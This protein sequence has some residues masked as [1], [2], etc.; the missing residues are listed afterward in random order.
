MR[1]RL[2]LVVAALLLAATALPAQAASSSQPSSI[3]VPASWFGATPPL[4]PGQIELAVTSSLPSTVTGESA[5]IEVR[6]LKAGDPLTV[7]R[8]GTDVTGALGPVRDGV[9]GGVVRD[10]RV[11]TNTLTATSGA[12]RAALEV[13][14]HRITG[15]VISGP[16]QTPFVCETVANGMGKPLDADCSAPTQV[17]WYARSVSTRF[18]KLADP[19]APYPPD[20][21][22]TTTADGKTVPFVVRVESSVIN[23]S[24]TRVAVLD[25][26]HSRPPGAAYTPS[27]A[28]NRKLIYSFGESC[29]TGH[30][31][32]V[33]SAEN[34]L[35]EVAPS[36]NPYDNAFAPFLDLG[37]EL[38]KG[39]MTAHSTLTILGVECN[40]VVSAETLM[41][42]KE[43][44]IKDYGPLVHTLGAGA[45]GGA[46][47][48]YTAANNYP[49]IIDGGNAI[50][51]FPDMETTFVT[52][53]DCLLLERAFRADPL[54]WTEPKQEAVTGFRTGQICSDWTSQYA[55]LVDPKH[56]DPSVPAA[57][58]YDPR[59]NPGGVRCA[60]QDDL[61]NIWGRDP[62]TGFAR[63]PL[64]N[65]GVQYGLAAL[66]SGAITPADFMAL[67]TAVGGLDIDGNPVRQRMDMGADVARIAYAT[68]RVSGRGA[69]NQTPIID[70]HPNLDLV[71]DVD[72]HDDA[73]PFAAAARMDA[74]LGGHQSLALWQGE[75]APA[76]GFGPLEQWLAALDA[77]RGSDASDSARVSAVAATR[78]PAA[79]DRC[80][81]PSGI[82][83]RGTSPCSSLADATPRQAAG[84]PRSEDVLKCTLKPVDRTDYP[85][86]VTAVDLAVLRS[87]FPS[88]VCNW[89]VAGVGETASSGVW[90]S[91]GD[92]TTSPSKPVQLH[93]VVAR[94]APAGADVLGVTVSAHGAVP[95]SRLPATG[96]DPWRLVLGLGALALGAVALRRR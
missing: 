42:V 75:P 66:R 65:T 6:G 3:T 89:A 69:L 46:I 87:I 36:G 91:F 27:P 16:H 48:Q 85:A 37:S 39:Y 67:N 12:R 31:Q 95:T 23:R 83:I 88:G 86:S 13:V 44:I 82:G 50:I 8:N 58:V 30:H 33:N 74:H 34:A 76:D 40:E 25:D 4:G 5:R 59:K 22:T 72:V 70:S 81:L 77:R 78:P 60:L 64:D 73:R 32:G 93:N 96:D 18:T 17:D 53:A 80:T 54:R 84:G 79:S 2:G 41:M 28:W 51:S 10:L 7:E 38:G 19:S 55:V 62:A 92:G 20:T 15:P 56:C 35:G 43:H 57:D 29:A 11:G 1:R 90:L 68:G 71:P 63:R 61:V 52:D 47:Q 9:V 14:D 24:V 49:G 94:S 26:P 21:A 45:S